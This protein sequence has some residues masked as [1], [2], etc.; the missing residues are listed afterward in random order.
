MKNRR[1]YYRILHVQ[2]DAPEDIIRA[3]YRTLMQKLKMH[4]DL[5]GDEWNAALL[6][7]AYAVLCDRAKRAAYDAEFRTRANRDTTRG[8]ASDSNKSGQHS[9]SKNPESRGRHETERCPFCGTR[10]PTGLQ[11]GNQSHCSRCASP[12]KTASAIEIADNSHRALARMAHRAPLEFFTAA[13]NPV[14][15]RGS[16][17]DLSPKGLQFL[18]AKRL[19]K[20]QVIKIVCATL[21]A[22]A[23]VTHCRY[24]E[25]DG[26]FKV[27]VEFLT[28]QFSEQRG[29]FISESA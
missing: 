18:T 9:R 21:S 4:P 25:A 11:Y 3:S 12:L 23:R 1:N 27:G 29:T 24:S 19:G 5:G 10:R 2:P 8:G 7:E 28:L 22:T 15:H 6:N 14:G 20:N 13:E 16:I 26:S 17:E